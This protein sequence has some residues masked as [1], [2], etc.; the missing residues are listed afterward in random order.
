LHA[1]DRAYERVHC[2]REGAPD[3]E[4]KDCIGIALT[5]ERENSRQPSR[6]TEAIDAWRE[7]LATQI[8]ASQ[9]RA[10]GHGNQSI[11]RNGE[12]AL[13]QSRDAII[14]VNRPTERLPRG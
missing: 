4:Y 7:R 2:G 13:S 11:V 14:V 6:T 1:I 10:A 12:I 5:V 3:P 9:V 8:L